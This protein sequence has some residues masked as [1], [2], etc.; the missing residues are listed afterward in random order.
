MSEAR[1]M[2]ERAVDHALQLRYEQISDEAKQIAGWL[3]FDS[4]GTGLG[5][6]Q[7]ERGRKA[8]DYAAAALPGD[9]ATLLGS[10]ARASAEG[11]AFANGTMIK[12]LG[13]DDSHRTAGHIA[14]QLL[15]AVL[16][17]A[18]RHATPGRRVIEAIVA[19]YDIAVPLGRAVRAPQRARGLDLKGT[20][21][22]IVAALAAGRCADLDR[23]TLLQAVGLAADMASGTEQY[24]YEG[25]PC[26]SKDLISGTAAR[27][28]VFAVQLAQ[29]GFAGP[30]GALDGEYGFLRAYGDGSGGNAFD[31]LGSEFA[32]TGTAFKPHGGCRHTH[33][34]VDAVQSLLGSESFDPADI[35]RVLIRTYRYALQPS[36]RT[37]PDPPA[38]EV[39]G[40][41]IRVATAIALTG[42]SAWPNDFRRWDEAEVRRLRRVT[43]IEIDP[44]VEGVYPERNGATVE[45]TLRE[46]RTL[47]GSVP[48]AK[49]E[50]EFRMTEA[51]LLAKF[52]ALTGELLP[53]G[54]GAELFERCSRL[55]RLAGVDTLLE[56]AA[57]RPERIAAR[58]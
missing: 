47:T 2:L 33:Q 34:A 22:P 5:G 54:R 1:T 21:G 24:V 7:T 50:P 23:D 57:A 3:I 32:I 48:W 9:D 41:S 25:G 17:L 46:G 42:G 12:V 28:G 19:A 16:A 14:A 36:F 37:D 53:P 20:T 45:I 11:A 38:R 31:D 58:P 29:S 52:D 51:E 6:Y 26:D 18:E 55:E 27:N 10:G 49:G 44:E 56:L 40:L 39:A 15:P 13:M 35:E 30:A 4:I 8:A 43:D